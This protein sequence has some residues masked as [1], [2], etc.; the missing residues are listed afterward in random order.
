VDEQTGVYKFL[1]IGEM[2]ETTTQ[3]LSLS[4]QYKTSFGGQSRPQRKS[5][6]EQMEQLILQQARDY[7]AEVREGFVLSAQTT[8][9]RNRAELQFLLERVL[10]DWGELSRELGLEERE[11]AEGQPIELECIRQQ[12]VAYGMAVVALGQLPRLPA[13]HVTFPYSYSTPPTYSDIPTPDTAGEM[14]WRIEELEQMIWQ[15]MSNDLQALVERRYGALRRT[16]GF[17]ETS[18]LLANREAERFGLKKKSR[19][20]KMF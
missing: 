5:G 15:L 10:V 14:L 8:K 6:L 16:Y 18:A 19:P 11:P 17:F 4:L 20:L 13:E 12:L 9:V 3:L 1:S 2:A 7:L